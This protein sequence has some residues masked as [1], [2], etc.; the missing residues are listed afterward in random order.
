[1]VAAATLFARHR[2]AR[3]GL[4]MAL[5]GRCG[6]VHVL[7]A[8]AVAI[9]GPFVYVAGEPDGDL[10]THLQPDQIVVD[11][12]PQWLAPIGKAFPHRT[13]SRR[14][15]YHAGALDRAHL[16]GFVA[17]HDVRPVTPELAERLAAEVH[18]NQIPFPEAFA[19]DGVGYCVERDGRLVAGATAGMWCES[20][21][22][23]QVDTVPAY[24]RQGLAAAVSARLIL[25]CLERGIHPGWETEDPVSARLAERLGYTTASNYSWLCT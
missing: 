22:E 24:R 21:I 3:A 25:H 2:H 14:Q 4:E 17:G 19:M 5:T 23:I 12:P 16:A 6:D 1:M 13:T 11:P 20:E 7:A 18:V 9:V 15:T 8:G 10:L